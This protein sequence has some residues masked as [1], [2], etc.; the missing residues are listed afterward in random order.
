MDT[1]WD[2]SKGR[3]GGLTDQQWENLRLLIGGFV[4]Q[5]CK[6]VL[7]DIQ[8]EICPACRERVAR[9]RSLPLPFS[10]RLHGAYYQHSR[11]CPA[12]IDEAAGVV[13]KLLVQEEPSPELNEALD[14]VY[15]LIINGMERDGRF[16]E[17]E[18]FGATS[19]HLLCCGEEHVHEPLKCCAADCW[20]RTATGA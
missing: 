9:E 15:A 1:D 13:L 3:P 19:L 18:P 16:W 17:R 14:R 11:H 7:R 12:C 4:C 20:C 5:E 10:C 8:G 6:R 2:P